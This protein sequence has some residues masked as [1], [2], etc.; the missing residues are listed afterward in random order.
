MTDDSDR[1]PDFCIALISQGTV[2]MELTLE[3]RTD[4]HGRPNDEMDDLLTKL[5][6]ARPG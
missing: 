5:I 2:R 1:M 3:Q 6:T 4:A